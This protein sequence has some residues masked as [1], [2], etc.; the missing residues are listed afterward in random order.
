MPEGDTISKLARYLE[1]ALQERELVAGYVR[2]AESV[3]LAGSRIGR[4]FSRSKHLF[5][6]LGDERLLRSHLGMRGSWHVYA[7]GESWRKPR[8]QA[9]ILLDTGER[10][11]ICF[12][13]VAVEILRRSGVRRR[14]LD[15]ALGPD[16]LVDPVDHESI[17]QRARDMA[18]GNTPVL[19]VLLDQRVICGIGNVYK[20]EVLFLA[21]CHPETPLGQ[22]SDA[23]IIG[24]YRLASRLLGRNTRDGPRVTRMANDDAARL[25][26]YGRVGLPCLECDAVIRAARLGEDRRS[27]Y[28]CPDCQAALTTTGSL[29]GCPKIQPLLQLP[30]KLKS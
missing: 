17:L 1:P 29:P 5:I 26:V 3:D 12:N 4:V 21:R 19:D 24:I 7:P 14:V 27:T 20:S 18:D 2:T 11:F 28:W 9:S 22:L 25:W 16:L 8:R 30:P 23:C 10:V 6:E 13:A 15:A